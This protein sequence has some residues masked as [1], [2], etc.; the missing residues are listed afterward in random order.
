MK[1]TID[2]SKSKAEIIRRAE[3]IIGRYQDMNARQVDSINRLLGHQPDKDAPEAR[4]FRYEHE[5]MTLNE[6]LGLAD[7]RQRS[8]MDVISRVRQ[9]AVDT[10]NTRLLEILGGL[11]DVAQLVDETD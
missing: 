5:L 11:G 6:Q 8:I 10:E 3:Q 2:K 7:E 9:H 1:T 4:V